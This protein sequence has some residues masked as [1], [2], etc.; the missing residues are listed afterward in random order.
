M[1]QVL[2]LV[3]MSSQ[4]KSQHVNWPHTQGSSDTDKAEGKKH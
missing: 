4:G 2:F 3:F 1:A